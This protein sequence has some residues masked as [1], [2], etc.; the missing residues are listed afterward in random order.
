M[1]YNTSGAG[2]ANA[3]KQRATPEN[4]FPAPL[5]YSR[6]KPNRFQRRVDP[7]SIDEGGD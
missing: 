6:N 2:P 3:T 1:E 5:K 7:I 4:R